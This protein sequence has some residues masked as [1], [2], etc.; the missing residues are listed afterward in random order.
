MNK[1]RQMPR[2]IIVG[3]GAGGLELTARLAKKLGKN[4]KAVITLVD[5][6]PLHLWKPLLH[7]VAAGTLFSYEDEI[8]YLAYA[9]E[10]DFHFCL[11]TLAGLDRSK[12]QIILAPILDNNQQQ[13]IPPRLLDYDILVLAVGS[14]SNDFNVPGVQQCC[15]FL[16]NSEQAKHYQQ[17][18]FNT[19]MNFSQQTIHDE[20]PLNIAIVGAGA[21]GVELAAELHYAVNQLAHYGFDFDPAKVHIILLEAS[22]R[23]L[24]ALSQQLSQLAEKELKRIG[25]QIYTNAKVT[26][27]TPDGLYTNTGQ[28]IPAIL[29]TWAAG[30]KAPDIL[31][32]LDGLEVNNINQLIVKETLQT[33]QDDSIFALGDCAYCLLKGSDRPVPPR[34]QAAHQQA[35][36]L[37]KNIRAY[38]QHKPLLNYHYRDHGSLISF[39]RYETIGNLMGR[40]TNS[41]IIEGK[42]ARLAYLSLYRSHQI[43]LFGLWRVAILMLANW[44]TRRIR[45]R[46]KLH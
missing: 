39:S 2:I 12:K 30:I 45:P 26:E 10:H 13:V 38:L 3:G 6:S 17:Q 20:Q 28:F 35:R 41:F 4:H 36:L 40:I 14:T 8:E 25:I 43:S 31:K 33:T 44:L 16:D 42:L 21:T 18:L 1:Q 34:A 11:G 37:A 19:M 29:K 22:N 23:I 7:E 9:S 24:P 46:L 27:V 5:R 15:M 32:N